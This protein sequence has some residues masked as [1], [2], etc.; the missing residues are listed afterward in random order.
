MGPRWA[1]RIISSISCLQLLEMK[2]L[3]FETINS[4]KNDLYL[5]TS[6]RTTRN[7]CR[8][9]C[10]WN[11]LAKAMLYLY[12]ITYPPSLLLGASIN[13]WMT[14]SWHRR[15]QD[16]KQPM[17]MHWKM[18]CLID[19]RAS[20]TYF[21]VTNISF[22]TCHICTFRNSTRNTLTWKMRSVVT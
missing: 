4:E 1:N 14:C 10:A 9:R 8:T 12:L 11:H 15:R 18:F 6:N 21:H 13:R 2:S 7:H 22:V 19:W 3:I 16:N 20:L 17:Q 5:S